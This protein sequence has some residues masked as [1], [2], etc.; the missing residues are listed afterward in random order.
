MSAP[1]LQ[2]AATAGL[3]LYAQAVTFTGL[4]WNTGTSAF[5][6]KNLANWSLYAIPLNEP[7]TG[8]YFGSFPGTIATGTY[9]I[10]VYQQQTVPGSAASTDCKQGITLVGDWNLSSG[11]F[12]SLAPLEKT[13]GTQAIDLPKAQTAVQTYQNILNALIGAELQFA[14]L[15]FAE[16]SVDGQMVRFTSPKLLAERIEYYTKKVALLSGQRRRMVGMG[17]GGSYGIGRGAP[18]W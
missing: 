7:V 6:A 1:N 15:P 2:I 16:V 13:A 10:P 12:N 4:F 8:T 17:F 18:G 5:E 14:T 9:L 11:S 3:T